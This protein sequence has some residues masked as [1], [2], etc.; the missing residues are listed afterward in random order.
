MDTTEFEVYGVP[1]GFGR[2]A[3]ASPPPVTGGSGGGGNL[4]AVDR[5]A[6]KLGL[7]LVAGQRLKAV[8]AKGLKLR[9]SCDESCSLTVTARLD[10]KTARRVKLLS[11][12]SRAKSVTVAR[13][14]LSRRGGRRSAT[15]RLTATARK[16]LARTRSVKLSIG[17]TARDASGN[18][19]TRTVAVTVK[20]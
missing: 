15:L 16:R 6:P 7:A 4:A 10:A 19:R 13:G 1:E 12:H 20:R 11:R 2:A 9:V 17:V 5:T 14:S 18:A 3:P 8:L